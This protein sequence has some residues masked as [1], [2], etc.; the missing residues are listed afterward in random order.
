MDEYEALEQDLQKMYDDYMQKFRNQAYLEQ[1]LEEYNRNEQDKTEVCL[2]SG[3]T[4]GNKQPRDRAHYFMK[5]A[6]L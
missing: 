2:S 4:K 1:A 5:D 3:L 6:F